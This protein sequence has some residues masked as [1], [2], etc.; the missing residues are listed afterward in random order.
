M[1]GGDQH[2]KDG[3]RNALSTSMRNWTNIDKR[4][5]GFPVSAIKMLA[6]NGAGRRETIPQTQRDEKKTKTLIKYKTLYI[7]L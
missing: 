3:Q 5:E 7:Y 2:K 4:A 6:A 1:I